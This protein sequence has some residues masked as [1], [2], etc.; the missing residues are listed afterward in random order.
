MA[1]VMR[2]H[3]KNITPEERI[4]ELE[5]K[6]KI[7]EKSLLNREIESAMMI[8][9]AEAINSGLSLQKTMDLTAHHAQK[10]IQSESL[11]IPVLDKNCETY[12]YKAG[13]G[14]NAKEIVGES[15]P[16]DYGVCGWVWKNK[17]PWWKGVLDELEENERNLWEKEAGSI[18]MVPLEGKNHFLGGLSGI[19]KVGGGEFDKRDLDIL[20]LFAHKSVLAIENAQLFENLNN[21]KKQAE[22]YQ[23][24]LSTLNRELEKRIEKRTHALK[25][26]NKKL[27]HIALFDSL[28]GL[29]NRS[30][31]LNRLEIGLK[32][33]K[34]ENRSLSVIMMDLNK[35][36]NVNDTMGHDAGDEVLKQASLIIQKTLTDEDTIGRLGGDEFVLVLP[37]KN[38]KE[39]EVVAKDILSAMN[40]TLKISGHELSIGV[41]LGIATFPKN[42]DNKT[43]LLKYADIAM[44]SAKHANM[45]YSA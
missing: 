15:L 3:S 25:A 18:I 1:V 22:T 26:M 42:G 13:C 19:N 41:S 34:N 17:R 43:A 5:N 24:K 8:E 21:A 16:L 7:L 11:L 37:N 28:T 38:C 2:A 20:V 36:K 10:L 27:E 30:L 14:E 35:F 6:I 4:R 39:A 29:A 23:H 45:G 31:I 44:Y 40:C 33:S 32:N 9:V 12:T